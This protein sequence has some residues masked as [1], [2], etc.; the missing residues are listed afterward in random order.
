LLAALLVP[1]GEESR[2]P[3]QVEVRLQVPEAKVNHQLSLRE[4]Q[5][6]SGM[7]S[8]GGATYVNG[9]TRLVLEVGTRLETGSRVAA[10]GDRSLWVEAVEVRVGYSAADIFIPSEYAKGTCPYEVVLEHEREH[11][12]RDRALLEDFAV[13]LRDEL[14]EVKWPTPAK[15]L[16]SLAEEEGKKKVQEALGTVLKRALAELAKKRE[17]TRAALDTRKNYQAMRRRCD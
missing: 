12:A 7:K 4:V 3:A 14:Q 16:A 6:E 13:R 10:G 15:P 2:E 17:E 1:A 8:P 9:F 11:V 5:K